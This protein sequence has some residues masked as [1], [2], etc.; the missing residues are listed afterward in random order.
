MSAGPE[1]ARPWLRTKSQEFVRAAIRTR[2][3]PTY[4]FWRVHQSTSETL[5][6][7]AMS[8]DAAFFD[9]G[10]CAA[11]AHEDDLEEC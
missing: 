6:G 2:Q 4:L 8:T 1:Y 5:S 10:V 3:R 7:R 11:E 9:F